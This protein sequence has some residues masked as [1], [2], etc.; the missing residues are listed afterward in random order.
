VDKATHMLQQGHNLRRERKIFKEMYEKLFKL[1]DAHSTYK[2]RNEQ[3]LE[4]VAKMKTS[5]NATQYGKNT[6][7]ARVFETETE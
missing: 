5:S 7:V 3:L 2:R 1:W 4:K 6:D